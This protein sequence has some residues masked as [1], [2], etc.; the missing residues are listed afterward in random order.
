[1]S[2]A[3]DLLP[4]ITVRLAVWAAI[5]VALVPFIFLLTT[6]VKPT[7]DAQAVPPKWVFS[8]TFE[9]YLA[10]FGGQTASSQ[11]FLP[12]LVNSAIVAVASTVLTIALG[13]PAAY[14]LA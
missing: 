10:V 9:H 6:S 2:N 5:A 4:K 11:A 7:G 13:L 12:L 3:T 1:M 8:P 14:A